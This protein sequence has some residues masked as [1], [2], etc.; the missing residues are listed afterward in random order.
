MLRLGQSQ[1][2]L[3]RRCAWIHPDQAKARRAIP[4]PLNAEAIAIIRKNMG[5]HQTYVFTFRG[6]KVTQVNTKVW[7]KALGRCG[8][9]DFRWHDLRHTWASWHVQEGTPLHILQELGGWESSEMVRRYA[10]LSAEHLAPFADRLC[11]L[12][13]VDVGEVPTRIPTVAQ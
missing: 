9:D 1:I 11:A 10:H 6:K 7:Q 8:I 4:V 3:V 5:M 2:D 12:K 13:V